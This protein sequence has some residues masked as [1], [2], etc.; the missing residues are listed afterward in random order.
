M[1]WI[2][3]IKRNIERDGTMQVKLLAIDVDGTLLNDDHQLTER[4]KSA[5]SQIKERGVKVV[6][7]T[8]RGPVSCFPIMEEL[9]LTEPIITHNGAVIVG[10]QTKQIALEIG[11][12]AEEL[13]PIIQYCRQTGIHFDASTAFEMYVEG[14]TPEADQM[15]KK[16][17]AN[18]RMVADTSLLKDQIVKFTLFGDEK[19]MDQAL[20]EV[21]FK[22]P[23]WSIIRSGET[24]IDVIHPKATKGN[25]LK[26]ILKEQNIL[27]AQV[28]AFG[29]YY[30]DLEMIQLAGIGVAMEN[31]PEQIRHLADRITVS[32]NDDGVAVVIEEIISSISED[33]LR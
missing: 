4:T 28:I 11:F 3:E 29:N 12:K 5:I 31:S 15:Y 17:F 1:E 27:P 18:P 20:E 16:F 19:Q 6:L 24:F 2:K 22:F 7:A 30:N 14:R 8:G 32:N 33:I 23:D 9:A 25:A 26:R 10:P 13:L 21:A